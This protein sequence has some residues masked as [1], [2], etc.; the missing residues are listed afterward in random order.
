M[1]PSGSDGGGALPDRIG[2]VVESASHRYVAQCYGLYESPPLGA[3]VRTG[4]SPSSDPSLSPLGKGGLREVAPLSNGELR[5]VAGGQGESESHHVYAVVYGVRTE[6]LDPTRPVIAR[7]ED[8]RT[9][10]DIYRSNPQLERLL[11]TR[12][13][14]LIVGHGD[15]TTCNQYLPAQPPRI[16]SFVYSCTSE[17]VARFTGSMDFLSLL[18]NSSPAGRGVTDDVIAACVRQA[19]QQSD[20]SRS[21]LVRGGKALAEQLPTDLP[22]LNS[23]LRRLSP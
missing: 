9:E 20:D 21:F 16:H 8:E 6:A 23:I 7:G 19:S 2:E 5:G 11:C 10:E 3:F 13:E 17:E 14:A 4:A 12:F 15:G 1:I 22:R 18:L